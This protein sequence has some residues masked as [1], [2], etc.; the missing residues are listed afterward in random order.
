M[1]ARLQFFHGS[2]DVAPGKGTG[3]KETAHLIQRDVPNAT[4]L[5]AMGKWRSVLSNFYETQMP[6][7]F[8]GLHY[9]TAEH[10]FQAMK[11]A[12]ADTDAARSFALE[13]GSDLSKGDGLAA[14]KARKLRVL[15]PSMLAEWDLVRPSIVREMWKEK[16][17]Q[18]PRAA[19]VLALTGDAELWHVAPRMPQERWR[20]LEALRG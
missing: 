11:I 20:D 3:E 1:P 10:I 17:S 14:R 4:A 16:F 6:I 8:R 15:T 9:R 7:V 13:S 5:E 2:K 18:D 12:I 19:L